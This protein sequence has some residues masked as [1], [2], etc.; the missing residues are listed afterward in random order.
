MEYCV[1]VIIMAE[2]WIDVKVNKDGIFILTIIPI[3]FMTLFI[4]TLI[5]LLGSGGTPFGRMFNITI[6]ILFLIIGLGLPLFIYLRAPRSVSFSDSEILLENRIG[7]IN[8]MPKEQINRLTS[9]KTATT[10]ELIYVIH[11]NIKNTEYLIAFDKESG[12][13]IWDWY[14]NE[15]EWKKEIVK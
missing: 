15:G 6:A 2:T 5:R 1:S 13:T 3:I 11:Y 7:K 14:Y 4:L 10:K 8:I 9:M 12:K